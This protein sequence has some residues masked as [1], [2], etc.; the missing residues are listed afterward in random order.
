MLG[1]TMTQ[2]Y[3]AG[4]DTSAVEEFRM[5]NIRI[6][7]IATRWREVN[8][9][10]ALYHDPWFR[11]RKL[12]FMLKRAQCAAFCIDP[13]QIASRNGY[14]FASRRDELPYLIFRN[15]KCV[16]GPQKLH[17]VRYAWKYFSEC[18]GA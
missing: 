2:Y 4:A 9:I 15:V 3:S 14:G 7:V 13:R 18:G 11:L 10:P 12:H 6:R 1:L 17:A 8:T 5:H 16:Y